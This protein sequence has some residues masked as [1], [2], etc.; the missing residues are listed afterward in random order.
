MDKLRVLVVD[1]EFG[2]RSGIKR[3]LDKFEVDY[4]FM[5]DPIGFEVS[6]A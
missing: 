4:P 5:D 1:D 2:I 3:I 6:E